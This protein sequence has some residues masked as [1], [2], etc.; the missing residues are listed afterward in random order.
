[1]CCTDNIK[2]VIF[3]NIRNPYCVMFAKT[4]SKPLLEPH[5]QVS[6]MQTEVLLLLYTPRNHIVL[7]SP[8]LHLDRYLRDI[9]ILDSFQS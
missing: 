7:A 1:M 5:H 2:Q 6:L 9:Y 3:L 8:T 4:S